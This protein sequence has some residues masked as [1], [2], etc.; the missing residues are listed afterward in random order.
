MPITVKCYTIEEL[1]NE[2][3]KIIIKTSK[4]V[5]IGIEQVGD[6]TILWLPFGGEIVSIDSFDHYRVPPSKSNG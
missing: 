4:G 3:K 6:N 2:N 5:E 1:C